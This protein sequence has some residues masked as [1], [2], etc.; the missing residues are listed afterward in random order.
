M[1]VEFNIVLPQRVHPQPIPFIH[2]G[3]DCGACC[4]AGILGVTPAQAYELAN[5]DPTDNCAVGS[6]PGMRKA[7]WKLESEGHLAGH[8]LDVPFWNEPDTLAFWGRPAW[9]SYDSWFRYLKLA[10]EAGYY[11]IAPVEHAHLGPFATPNHVVL[12]CGVRFRWEPNPNLKGSLVG[13]EEILVSDSSTT[14]PS[15]PELWVGPRE[16]LMKWGGYVVYLAKP[17]D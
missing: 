14:P 15:V 10:L 8:I 1:S 3:G 9:E 2:K 13:K 7:L 4:L 11:A 5:H 17:K 12:I 6:G 16:F